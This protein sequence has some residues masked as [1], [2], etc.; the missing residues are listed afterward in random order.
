MATPG[1]PSFYVT[2]GTLRQAGRTARG[3]KTE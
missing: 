3:W 2:G 1:A